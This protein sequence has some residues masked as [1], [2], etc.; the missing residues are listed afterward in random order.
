[1][2]GDRRM[3]ARHYRELFAG[4]DTTEADA[5]AMRI[6]TFVESGIALITAIGQR[7]EKGGRRG[8]A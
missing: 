8:G 2:T 7:K 6:Q 4:L 3:A 1:M 5:A